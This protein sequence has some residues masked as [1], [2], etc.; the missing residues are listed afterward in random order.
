MSILNVCL[1]SLILEELLEN[2]KLSTSGYYHF[3][4]VNE[5]SQSNSFMRI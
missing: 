5:A 2:G 4:Y 1:K 3:K